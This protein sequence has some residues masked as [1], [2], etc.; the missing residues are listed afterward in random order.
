M[1]NNKKIVSNIHEKHIGI[2]NPFDKIDFNDVQGAIGE[3][4]EFG[5]SILKYVS[6]FPFLSTPLCLL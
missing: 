3:F 5:L 6:N 4:L 1:L 2:K